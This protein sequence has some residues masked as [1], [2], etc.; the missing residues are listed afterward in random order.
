[1]KV[2]SGFVSN[3]SSTSFVIVGFNVDKNKLLEFHNKLTNE[4]RD[5]D[6]FE[7]NWFEGLFEGADK[8]IT[9]GLC[10]KKFEWDSNIIIGYGD[11]YGD[12]CSSTKLNDFEENI[13][14]AK[15]LKEILNIEEDIDV[16]YGGGMDN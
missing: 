1:M 2:R 3:S 4:E 6:Y 7:D 13:N 14:K 8:E 5:L 15:K 9:K 10:T 16:W 11:N 12:E